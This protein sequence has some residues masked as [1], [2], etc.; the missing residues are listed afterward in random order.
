MRAQMLLWE[1]DLSRYE[2]KSVAATFILALKRMQKN[3]PDGVILL[4][5]LNFY[6]PEG[7]PISIF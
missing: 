6:N 4:R 2:E 3:A 5:V 1:N 7:I